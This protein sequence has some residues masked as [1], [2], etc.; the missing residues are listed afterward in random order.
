MN[1][2]NE[3]SAKRG[4]QESCQTYTIIW[5]DPNGAKKFP[6]TPKPVTKEIA[7]SW[8]E[9]GAVDGWTGQLITWENYLKEISKNS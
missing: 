3:S 5:T 7:E 6:A 9:F 2:L 4:G 8:I 1:N